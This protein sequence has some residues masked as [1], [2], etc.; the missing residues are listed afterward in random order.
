MIEMKKQYKTRDGKAARILAT[1]LR[2]G[3][4][5]VAAAITYE[6]GTEG[7]Y[8][9]R[10][11]GAFLNKP[12]HNLDLLEVKPVREGWIRL[13]STEQGTIYPGCS[14]Y[15]T[16]ADAQKY[17]EAAAPGLCAIV[18]IQFTEGEGL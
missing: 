5:S 17:Q 3:V 10:A 16:R 11:D 18:K 2:G 7:V 4:D 14:F 6:N 15:P 9:F 8:T 13:Y 1:D 12:G